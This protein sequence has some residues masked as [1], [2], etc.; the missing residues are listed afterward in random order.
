MQEHIAP[1]PTTSDA[2]E[3]PKAPEEASGVKPT[4][5][6]SSVVTEPAKIDDPVSSNLP[7][8][9]AAS[10]DNPQDIA[11]EE[12]QNEPSSSAKDDDLVT[13]TAPVGTAPTGDKQEDFA[14][15]QDAPTMTGALSDAS[16]PSDLAAAPAP[17]TAQPADE[18]TKEA[19]KTL[20][21][22]AGE[23]A[24]VRTNGT[25]KD[26]DMTDAPAAPEETVNAAVA[27]EK[28]KAEEPAP[29]NGEAKKAKSKTNGSV[30]STN[31]NGETKKAGRSGKK[32]KKPLE[33]AK[34]VVGRTLRKTRSQGPVEQ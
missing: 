3:P 33:K 29:T 13:S 16:N 18:A 7:V 26:T 30:A 12:K 23:T 5:D 32:D 21:K 8:G 10:G 15:K 1:A 17:D 11:P 34:E 14:P 4:E 27:G 28:R 22:P 25:E 2:P 6:K 20:E 19:A 31:S 9:T 24:A